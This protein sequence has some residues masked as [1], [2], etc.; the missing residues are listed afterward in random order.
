MYSR[1]PTPRSVR[2]LDIAPGT[3][4]EPVKASLL[5]VELDAAPDFEALSYVWGTTADPVVVACDGEPISV[6]QN[7]HAALLRLRFVDVT[8]RVW[9]DALCINQNNLDERSQQ[10][11]F[12]KDIY[13]RA[14]HVVVWLG[15]DEGGQALL[16]ISAIYSILPHNPPKDSQPDVQ[17]LVPQDLDAAHWQ[18]MWWLFTRE[19][20]TRGWILQEI[21]QDPSAVMMVGDHQ[22]KYSTVLWAAAKTAHQEMYLVPSQKWDRMWLNMTI[23]WVDTYIISRKAQ[24][25]PPA[26]LLTLL[27]RFS[28]SKTTDPRDKLFA[29]IGLSKEGQEL[30]KYPLIKPDYRK[31]VVKTFTD[32]VR[33]LISAL[34]GQDFSEGGLDV[35]GTAHLARWTWDASVKNFPSWVPPFYQSR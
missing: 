4:S 34:R 32:L 26:P 8:R 21:A 10:V 31:S 27:I 1:L 33:Q 11:S 25:L 23:I 22:I 35:L 19:W 14:K 29:L 20:F 12:M 18:A 28:L 3:S 5:V 16:A 24:S 13:G 9:I 17:D 6:T 30:E 15:P 2:L 7:L